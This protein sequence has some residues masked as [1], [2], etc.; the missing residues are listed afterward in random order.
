MTGTRVR[1][2][3][4]SLISLLLR[5]APRFPLA[6]MLTR[7]VR[8]IVRERPDLIDRLGPTATV[9]VAVI[10]TDLPFCFRVLLCGERARVDVVDAD[11]AA[12]AAARI[13]GPLLVLLGLMDGTYDGDAV[14]FSRDI[15]IEGDT[16]HV[17][18]LRNTLEEASLTP[19][20]FV[21]LTGTTAAYAN[22]GA[23]RLLAVA[24]RILDAPQPSS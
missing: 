9:P 16:E 23:N 18:A 14:F 15:V 11:E 7:A 10:P 2:G 21:G 3:L 20:E 22:S 4:P 24:R 17:L 12:T 6:L 13:R 5:P 19:A 1:G 8:R